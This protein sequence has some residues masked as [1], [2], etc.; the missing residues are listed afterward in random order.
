MTKERML[1]LYG[2]KLKKFCNDVLNLDEGKFIVTCDCVDWH[3][4]IEALQRRIRGREIIL[5][6][7][8]GWYATDNGFTRDVIEPINIFEWV[9]DEQHDRVTNAVTRI[10]AKSLKLTKCPM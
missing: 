5:A 10:V 6:E 2:D 1:E 7:V 9:G 3:C 8:K 4:E